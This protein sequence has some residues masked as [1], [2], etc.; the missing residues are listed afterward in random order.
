LV[1]DG[2]ILIAPAQLVHRDAG[3]TLRHYAH[4]TPLDD[5]DV[6]DELD[7]RLNEAVG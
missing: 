6:A 2:N 7:R 1:E 5:V 3:T 4:A